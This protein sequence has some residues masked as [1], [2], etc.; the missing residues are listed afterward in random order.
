LLTVHVL[1]QSYMFLKG[2]LMFQLRSYFC[3]HLFVWV[4]FYTQLLTLH[5]PYVLYTNSDQKLRKK[6]TWT[7]IHY[8]IGVTCLF[9]D[10]RYNYYTLL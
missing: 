9:N 4:G 10:T 5:Q 6:N 8:K 2:Y 7:N 1:L 3:E